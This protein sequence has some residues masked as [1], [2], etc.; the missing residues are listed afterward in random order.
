VL[1]IVG[2]HCLDSMTTAQAS[3]GGGITEVRVFH[4]HARQS[5]LK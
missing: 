3:G 5:A 1:G 4:Q 2:M